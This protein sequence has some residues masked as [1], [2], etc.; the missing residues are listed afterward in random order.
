MKFG[1][2]DGTVYPLVSK[3]RSTDQS[4]FP[5]CTTTL[6]LCISYFFTY[7]V[8]IFTKRTLSLPFHQVEGIATTNGLKYYVT[9]EHFTQPPIINNLHKLHV[10]QLDNYLSAYLAGITD[11]TGRILL[12]GDATEANNTV[13]ADGLS[14]GIYYLYLNHKSVYKPVIEPE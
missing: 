14:N 7:F 5:A 4:T 10:V 6:S 12:Y 1:F 3:A 13:V 8:R 11:L 9:N 2:D